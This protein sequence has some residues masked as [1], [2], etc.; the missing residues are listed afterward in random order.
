MHGGIIVK[1]R[2]KQVRISLKDK[3]G[4]K[5]TQAA[6][7]DELG[8][9]KAT[10][11]AFETGNRIPSE[12]IIKL[13]SEKFGVNETWLLTGEGEMFAIS[14]KEQEIARIT[15]QLFREGDDSFRTKLI[16]LIARMS[17]EQIEQCKEFAK[18]LCE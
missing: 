5:M 3:N 14:T 17:D 1:D 11:T 10:V 15:A 12:S 9:S 2:I 16:S 13:I 8:L 18:K 7:A 4:E 6:L